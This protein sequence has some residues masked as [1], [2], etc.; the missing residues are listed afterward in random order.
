MLYSNRKEMNMNTTPS[1]WDDKPTETPASP[2]SKRSQ[3][4]YVRPTEPTALTE[5]EFDIDGLMTDFP[6]ATESL[7]LE[8][9]LFAIFNTGKRAP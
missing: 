5:A 1:P 7:S 4:V 8:N 9:D 2:K 6:T 3:T